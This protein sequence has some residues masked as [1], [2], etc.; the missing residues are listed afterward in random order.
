MANAPVPAPP[1]FATAS[2]PGLVSTAAQSFGGAKTFMAKLI[3]SA[4]PLVLGLFATGGLPSAASNTG[5]IVYD[6]T[7]GAVKYSNGS[8]WANIASGI[9]GS[10]SSGRVAFWN[11]AS[12]VSSSADLF[13]DNATSA[14]GIK[15]ITPEAPLHVYSANPSDYYNNAI[16][17]LKSDTVDP[18]GI[19]LGAQTSN[20]GKEAFIRFSDGANA[21]DEIRW[22]GRSLG[23]STF[24]IMDSPLGS[25]NTQPKLAVGYDV[26]NDFSSAAPGSILLSGYLGVGVTN[27][28]RR[29]EVDGDASFT[30][31]VGPGQYAT[32]DL[33]NIGDNEGCIVYD[34]T[35]STVK[36]SDGSSW[37]NIG[38][39]GGGMAIGNAV[40]SSTNGS[41]LYSNAGNLA[42]SNSALYWDYTNT[43]LGIGNSGPTKTLDVTGQGVFS[44]ILGLAKIA[45]IS[46]PTAAAGNTGYIAYD[47]TASAIKFS[48]GTSWLAPVTAM[49]AI[50]NSPN[51]NGASISAD[52][53]FTLQP[54]DITFGGILSNTTQTILGKKTF[55]VAGAGDTMDIT[56]QDTTGSGGGLRIRN[57]TGTAGHPTVNFQKNSVHVGS[58]NG[59]DATGFGMIN[60]LNITAPTGKGVGFRINT[61]SVGQFSSNGDFLV[62]TNTFYVDS[63]NNRVGVG[64]ATPSMRMEVRQDQ[65]ADTALQ[66]TNARGSVGGNSTAHP[67]V[68]CYDGAKEVTLINWPIAQASGSSKM[69]DTGGLWCNKPNGMAF[70]NTA[71]DWKFLKDVSGTVTVLGRAIYSNGNFAWGEVGT[72]AFYVDS[73]NKRIGVGNAAPTVALDVT[74]AGKI[75][76]TLD[77]TGNVTVNTNALFV[78]AS[79]KFVGIGKT[80]TVALD[81]VGAAAISTTLAVT[82]NVTVDTNSLFVDATNHR[83]GV[84]TLTPSVELDVVGAGKISGNLTVDTTTLFVDATNNRVG[85]GTITPSVT[86]DVVGPIAFRAGTGSAAPTTSGILDINSTAAT[87]SGTSDTDLMS[88]TLPANSMVSNGHGIRWKASGIIASVNAA[89]TAT[90]SFYFGSQLTL[91][92]PVSVPVTTNIIGV[93]TFHWFAEITVLRTGASAQAYTA[94]VRV[95]NVA[96]ASLTPQTLYGTF[97]GFGTLAE[98]ETNAIVIKTKGLSTASNSTIQSL[99]I[100]EYI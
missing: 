22:K 68:R 47:S 24:Y 61:T 64:T 43:R 91:A 4:Q 28:I 77:V 58:I 75:S 51:A 45:T 69:A 21:D 14:L 40:T 84:K 9:T 1:P 44:D 79:S 16:F 86:L 11:G 29:M 46:L 94:E 25:D 60:G 88:Y 99:N 18:A 19:I 17:V 82:S 98:T 81:V 63:V 96:S 39:A 35:T 33:P 92:A 7:V 54:A 97:T 74:G 55:T 66:V 80:P 49:A 100:V 5:A 83:V 31:P 12:S 13:W 41:I 34:T 95:V 53:I 52:G 2:L 50:G 3:M 37:A 59:Y 42:Q 65:D 32:V 73:T 27:P 72:T 26:S 36:F 38:G 76:S 71:G 62:D 67:L 30:G 93:N 85:V 20:A 10:G 89:G 78:N 6:T 56:S 57:D 15:T 23:E 87:N 48:N 90:L 70:L 8:A